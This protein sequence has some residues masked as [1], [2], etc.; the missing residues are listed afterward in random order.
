MTRKEVIALS[1]RTGR[2]KSDNPKEI[3]FSVRFDVST[4]QKLEEYAA[5]NHITVAEV[6][7][8]AVKKFLKVK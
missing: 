6:I 4:N 1:V 3:R 5:E 2:P 8:R 7:R